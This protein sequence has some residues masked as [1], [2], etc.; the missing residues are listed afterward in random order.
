MYKKKHFFF[1]SYSLDLGVLPQW[2]TP[3]RKD[4]GPEEEFILETS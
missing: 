3:L 2:C 4:T 1:F